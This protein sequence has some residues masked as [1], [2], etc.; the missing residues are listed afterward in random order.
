M[1]ADSADRQ[2]EI[3]S[4]W[5]GAGRRQRESTPNGAPSR[6]FLYLP[7]CPAADFCKKLYLPDKKWYQFDGMD[8]EP[9]DQFDDMDDEPDDQPDDMDDDQDDDPDDPDYW[10]H[11]KR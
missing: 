6:R 4:S 11:H 3:A 7:R 1:A 8:D 5:D 2:N 9:D 10:L